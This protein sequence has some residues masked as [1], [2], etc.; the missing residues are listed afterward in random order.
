VSSRECTVPQAKNLLEKL[1]PK[2]NQVS[3]KLWGFPWTRRGITKPEKI[4]VSE[5]LLERYPRTPQRLWQGFAKL[6][7]PKQAE[8]FLQL[9]D[10]QN[11]GEG[12]P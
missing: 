8:D 6:T 5:K 11:R 7:D 9:D 2:K 10:Q 4:E 12:A 1:A 3:E